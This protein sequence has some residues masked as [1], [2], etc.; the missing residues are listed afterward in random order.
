MPRVSIPWR[1]ESVLISLQDEERLARALN[2]LATL[3]LAEQV[4]LCFSK[5]GKRTG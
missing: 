1:L 5:L 3:R 4:F 2:D